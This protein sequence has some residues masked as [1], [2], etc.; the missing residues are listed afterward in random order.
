MQ[1]DKVCEKVMKTIRTISK[2]A[3]QLR[4]RFQQLVVNEF[5]KKNGSLKGYTGQIYLLLPDYRK[6]LKLY[7]GFSREV[8]NEL[9]NYLSFEQSQRR[10]NNQDVF[11]NELQIVNSFNRDYI[12]LAYER[13]W[14]NAIST[15]NNKHWSAQAKALYNGIKKYGFRYYE[16]DYNFSYYELLEKADPFLVGIYEK[17]LAKLL[18]NEN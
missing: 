3:N 5:V 16:N 7:K 1:E 11:V 8:F 15:N 18:A 2:E 13:V 4:E 14:H 17:K 9:K 12:K 6:S 10:F